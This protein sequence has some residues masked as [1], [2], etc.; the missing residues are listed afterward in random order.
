LTVLF[1]AIL[2]QLPVNPDLFAFNQVLS[3]GLTLPTPD[4][5]IEEIRLIH[6]LVPVLFTTV[7][8]N[9]EFTNRLAI[10]GILEFCVPSQPP[11]QH[12]MV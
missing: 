2:T 1:P 3:Q 5:N 10:S 6:P 9:G 8:R 12:Y 4:D 7:H 11:D